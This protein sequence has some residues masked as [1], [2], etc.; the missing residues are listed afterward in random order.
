MRHYERSPNGFWTGAESNATNSLI[1]CR[2]VLQVVTPV[3]SA[4]STE[5]FT[6][7][8]GA[9]WCDIISAFTADAQLA[10]KPRVRATVLNP[11]QYTIGN[12]GV[13]KARVRSRAP[14]QLLQADLVSCTQ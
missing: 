3:F 9:A 5:D 13:E 7:A 12:H 2:D 8:M 1:C 10:Q 11:I 6:I 14:K 4:G